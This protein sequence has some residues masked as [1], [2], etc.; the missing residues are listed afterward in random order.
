MLWSLYKIQNP[1]GCFLMMAISCNPVRRDHRNRWWLWK[2]TARQGSPI[3][4]SLT[5]HLI[6]TMSSHVNL[7]PDWA[8]C[9]SN[10]SPWKERRRREG[11]RQHKAR[12]MIKRGSSAQ[13]DSHVH[14]QGFTG[15]S[16]ATDF[17]VCTC[18]GHSAPFNNAI[19][20]NLYEEANSNLS[21]VIYRK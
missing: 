17:L 10:Y 4:V 11:C 19:G 5:Q 3:T 1:I 15:S 7:L 6:S 9:H 13:G 20:L 21:K 8:V 14:T 12:G 16:L 18:S 2:C